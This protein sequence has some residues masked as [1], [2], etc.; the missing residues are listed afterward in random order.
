MSKR[1]TIVIFDGSF[2]T[3]SFINRLAVGLSKQHDVYIL[4]LNEVLSHKLQNVTY[5]SIGSNTN[6]L[7]F[8][9]TSLIL[10][11]KSLRI[12]MLTNT[13][14]YLIKGKRILLQKQNLNLVLDQLR[15]DIIHLQWPSVIPLFEDVLM[16][17]QFPVVLSQRGYHINVRPFVNAENMQYL[18]EWFPK[19]AGFHSVS[20][21]ISKTGDMIYKAPNKLDGVIYTG[22]PLNR[23]PFRTLYKRHQ[24]LKLISIGRSHWK[25]GFDDAILACKHLLDLEIPFTY[26]IV[27]G[28]DDEQLLYMTHDLGLTGFVSLEPKCS[29]NEVYD[30]MNEADML[31]MPSLEEGIA[32]VAVEAM[33]LGLPVISTTCGGMEELITN[34]ETGWLIPLRSPLILAKAIIGLQKAPIETINEVR[35]QARLKIEQQHAEGLMI[36]D[37]E[38]LYE[39]TIGSFKN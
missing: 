33:A 21:A 38:N 3:T 6:K 27:G 25:K 4:G 12:P 8:M 37:M 31:L 30:K 32:N 7:R 9:L 20:Q 23:F 29:Q 28:A 14:L 1:L 24:P 36:T 18:K 2:K 35:K 26:T 19:I 11:F 34:E 22:L 39:K 5:R 16:V 13:F 15:P 17:Q 10:A